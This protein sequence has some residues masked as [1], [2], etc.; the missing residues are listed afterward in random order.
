MTMAQSVSYRQEQTRRRQY[1]D[2]HHWLNE[3]P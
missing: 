2:L 1:D 3:L